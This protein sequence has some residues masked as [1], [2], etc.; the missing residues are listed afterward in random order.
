[1]SHSSSRVA[2]KGGRWETDPDRR[3]KYTLRYVRNGPVE[4]VRVQLV[5]RARRRFER[6][7]A[8][9]QAAFV[10]RSERR[11]ERHQARRELKE[12]LT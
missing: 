3:V 6:E 4:E 9:G 11:R 2:H 10:R 12:E 7:I 1:M 5:R 8:A